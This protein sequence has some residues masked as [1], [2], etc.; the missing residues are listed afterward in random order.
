M[1]DPYDRLRAGIARLQRMVEE[2]DD[3]IEHQ[4]AEIEYLRE[5]VGEMEAPLPAPM[6]TYR[7]RRPTWRH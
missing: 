2:R 4:D 7:M 3:I 1:T 5:L 6:P